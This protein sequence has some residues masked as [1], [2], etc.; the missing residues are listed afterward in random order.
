MRSG[1]ITGISGYLSNQMLKQL[2]QEKE[3]QTV[4]GIDIKPPSYFAGKL[5]FYSRDIREPLIDIF[6]QNKADTA[7]HLAFIVP[8]TTHVDAHS[9]DT[10]H[11]QRVEERNGFWLCW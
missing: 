2:D 6:D 5:K 9:I 10:G 3:V 1:P 11:S 7:L 4:V 8:P